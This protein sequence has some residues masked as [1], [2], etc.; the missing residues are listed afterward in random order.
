[1][2]AATGNQTT[3]WAYGTTL[4]SQRR[5]PERSARQRSPTPTA[6]LSAYAYNRLGEQRTITD[7][8][9]NVHTF[10][11]DRLGGRPT[12]AS[13]RLA[14]TTDGT[15]LQIAWAYEIR[16]MVNLITSYGHAT[17]GAARSSTKCALDLQQLRAA[18]E[19]T[20]IPRRRGLASSR[21]A[22]GYSL[23]YRQPEPAMRIGSTASHT[24]TGTSF[25]ITS[26][27]GMDAYLNRVTTISDS[28]ATLASYAYL[29]LA[30]VVRITYPQP[31][32]WL[33][34]WGGTSGTFAGLDLFNRVI[35]QRWQNS[36]TTTP[37][38]IDRYQY[39]YDST[40]TAIWKA[41]V[42]GTPVVTAGLDEYYL[43]DNLNRLTDMQRGVLN[44][45]AGRRP[46]SP[47]PASSSSNGRWTRPATGASSPRREG[48]ATM[49][50]TR[51][52]HGER[53]HRHRLGQPAV[54]AADGVGYARVRCRRKY[55]DDAAAG[56]ADEFLHGG[57]R[58]VEPDASRSASTATWWQYQ[59][60]GGFPTARLRFTTQSRHFFFT[61]NWQD[62]EQR[63][64]DATTMDQQH[65][66][67]IRYIDELVCRDDPT[68]DV[69]TAA[70]T[71][72]STSPHSPMTLQP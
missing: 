59:Y 45:T 20:A 29:G 3:T 53:D 16:G 42:V 32:V 19:R 65:V 10:Y 33:D 11:R 23:R 39:G 2:N 9:G 4:A 30:T 38:D 35:D 28:S 50:Q 63:V 61:N 6:A 72:T 1:M 21:R 55:D 69:C 34:L 41:N 49:T 71:R 36:I 31:S 60:D 5:G 43:M 24:R 46:E 13:P 26:A 27:P 54:D 67:G 66:W 47:A 7:Q 70:K 40:P 62:I 17:Q 18:C 25:L 58:C 51:T 52:E 37:A 44:C 56:D 14:L 68:P 48:S 12:T 64:G 22:V 57:L 15:V 8:R